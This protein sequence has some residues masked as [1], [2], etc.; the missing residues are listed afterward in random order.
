VQGRAGHARHRLGPRPGRRLTRRDLLWTAG[1]LLTLAA[2]TP[3]GSGA[4]PA[5]GA[6]AVQRIVLPRDMAKSGK[7]F[8]ETIA[9][10]RSQRDYGTLGLTLSQ[11][12]RLLH[13]ANGI[14]DPASGFRAAPSAGALYPVNTYVTV[15][16][17]EGLVAGLYAYDPAGHALGLLR[18]GELSRSL[19][20]VCLGQGSVGAAAACFV[21]AGQFERLASRY[22]GRAE[23]YTL[24]EVGHIAQNLCLAATALGLGACPIGAFDDPALNDLLGLDAAREPALYVV[25]V[26]SLP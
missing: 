21:L 18:E 4:P 23:R 7:G 10:R 2:C 8:E 24:L 5:T 26:G 1:G 9:Q 14:T 6:G 15:A 19:Q 20:A 17:V 11:V 12:S 16:R 25:A 13:S 3:E 22:R